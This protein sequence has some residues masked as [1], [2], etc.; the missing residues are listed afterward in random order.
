MATKV[1]TTPGRK[2]SHLRGLQTVK[3]DRAMRITSTRWLRFFDASHGFS[4]HV[5]WSFTFPGLQPAALPKES[6]GINLPWRSIRPKPTAAQR[7][8]LGNGHPYRNLAFGCCHDLKH[9]VIEGYWSWWSL[10]S[11]WQETADDSYAARKLQ[12]FWDGIQLRKLIFSA[13]FHTLM[14]IC[15]VKKGTPKFHW[16]RLFPMLMVSNLNEAHIQMVETAPISSPEFFS[17]CHRT[18]LGAGRR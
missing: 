12:R 16:W 18:F 11:L 1:I 6:N 9:Q 7:H 2:D 3:E 10:L 8:I 4:R 5:F 14:S 13:S 15:F 17:R